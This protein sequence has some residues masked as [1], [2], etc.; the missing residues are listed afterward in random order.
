MANIVVV[1]AQWGDEGKAKIVDLLA[2][3]AGFVVRYQGGNNAGHTVTANGK[4][5]KFHLIPSGILYSGKKCF[6]GNGTVIDPKSLL[7]EMKALEDE[8][9]D[10]SNLKISSSAHV[11]MPYHILLDQASE[12][13][14]G[15]KK[16]GTTARGIGPTYTD[17]VARTGIKINDL[18]NK[19]VLKERLEL[20][21]PQKN[22]VLSK[23][24]GKEELKLEEILE[25]Y[26]AFGEELRSYVTDVS[27]EL[28][29]GTKQGEKILFE[30]AQGTLLDIDH[31][32]YPFVTSSNPIAGAATT[33]TGLGPTAIHH[34]IGV[35]KAFNTRVGEGPFPTQIDGEDAKI[36][37][38]E[39]TPWAEF[40]TTTGR[41]RKVGWL[42]LVLLKLAVRVNGLTSVAITKLDILDDI[43]TIKACVAYKNTKTGEICNDFPAAADLE[44]FEPVLEEFAGW[45]STE[46]KCFGARS[47]DSLPENAKA[48]LNFIEEYLDTPVSIIGVGPGRDEIIIEK[49]P[50]KT[51]ELSGVNGYC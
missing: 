44:D 38:A 7:K 23:V 18:L 13:A 17:K 12:E 49:N 5:Y 2:E 19:D 37:V 22:K 20:A 24:F 45:K 3:D 14:R 1:G 40:G 34:V 29:N 33:G 4:K 10:L 43:E 36:L 15:D 6:I 27:L 32:T 25:E 39:G 11:T 35:A 21:L 8:G 28:W 41:A 48:Y 30:G 46:S 16:I 51:E 26:L 42:D 47:R 50:F 31:G 9:I